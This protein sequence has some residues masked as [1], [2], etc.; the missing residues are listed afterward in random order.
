MVF[1]PFFRF[2][3]L[4]LDPLKLP[5]FLLFGD[6]ILFSSGV[7]ESGDKVIRDWRDLPDFFLSLVPVGYFCNLGFLVYLDLNVLRDSLD[8]TS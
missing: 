5:L 4:P 3:W 6:F 8:L 7:K 2:L 1:A